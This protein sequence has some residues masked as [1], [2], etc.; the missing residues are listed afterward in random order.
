VKM[1]QRERH[2]VPTR[3]GS[4]VYLSPFLQSEC[5]GISALVGCTASCVPDMSLPLCIVHNPLA[6]VPIPP[7][8]FGR[9]AEEWVAVPVPDRLGY[10]ALMRVS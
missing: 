1:E 9:A 4:P 8:L 6:S 10:F 3:H 5:A 7:G 2:E